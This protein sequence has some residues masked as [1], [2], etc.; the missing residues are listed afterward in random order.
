MKVH[1]LSKR[2]VIYIGDERR[3]IKASHKADIPII[4]VT[5]GYNNKKMLAE[6]NPDYLVSQPKEIISI[7]NK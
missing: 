5:W 3:D 1:S 6:N 2:E 7:V 4:A